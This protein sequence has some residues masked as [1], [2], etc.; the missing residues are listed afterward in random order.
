VRDAMASVPQELAPAEY[1]RKQVA[2]QAQS[3]GML[4]VLPRGTQ[5]AQYIRSVLIFMTTPAHAH[6]A[7]TQRQEVTAPPPPALL[8]FDDPTQSFRWVGTPEHSS[9]AA[10]LRLE[11][12]HYELFLSQH[13]GITGTAKG[14]G[15][16]P[17]KGSKSSALNLPPGSADQLALLHEE[18]AQRY[19]NP[20]AS[21]VYTLRDGAKATV[22]PLGKKTGGKPREH[23]LLRLDR[24]GTATLLALVRDA[25]ARLPGGEGSRTDVCELLKESTFVIDG[26]NDAQISTVASGAL[27][28]L[29][30]EQDACVRY[31]GERKLWI[32]LHGN[33]A[34]D[35]FGPPA[36][37]A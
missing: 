31:D 24:P 9:N 7:R 4:A 13:G 1:V 2:I 11:A 34:L 19:A 25:A 14:L 3:G 8:E 20:E 6:A 27:D 37:Q 18:E 15:L 23:F 29:Q 33:R 28:R 10:L 36:K 21:F 26:A 12:L 5:L 35:S 16:A 30:S 32:Y 22:A 17:V